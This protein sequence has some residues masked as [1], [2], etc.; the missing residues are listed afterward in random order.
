MFDINMKQAEPENILKH[1]NRSFEFRGDKIYYADELGYHV[2]PE[3]EL[4]AITGGGGK[5]IINEFIDD[6]QDFDVVFMPG[7]IPH[8]WILDP[9]LCNEDGIINDCCCQFTNSFL[10]QTGN[11]FPELKPMTE[12][13]ANLRQA[14]RIEGEAAQNVI[15]AYHNFNS[16]SDGSQT[17]VLLELLNNIYE[18]GEYRLIGLPAPKDIHISRPRMRFQNINKLITENYGRTITLSEAAQSVSMNP[19]AFCNA[20]KATTGKTFNT[21][22]T[23]Y[24]LQVAARLLG[25]TMMNISEIAYKVGFGDLPHFT[26]TFKRYYNISPTEYRKRRITEEKSDI[27][28]MK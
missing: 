1:D 25:T 4:M 5:C 27:N 20:F 13:Y 10:T 28:K 22:L 11:S 3:M 21:Y 8:C 12:Y 7:G 18:S 16:Y 15:S 6:F 9:L 24:R 14:I 23:T 26:R 17:I 2:H 19:T